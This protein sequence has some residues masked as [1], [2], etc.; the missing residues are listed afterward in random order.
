MSRNHAAHFVL[1]SAL[2]WSQR[3][4]NGAQGEKGKGH[5]GGGGEGERRLLSSLLLLCGYCLP[6]FM[7]VALMAS[8]VKSVS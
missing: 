1:S 4:Q 2:T 6:N 5:G 3:Q 8:F 7:D